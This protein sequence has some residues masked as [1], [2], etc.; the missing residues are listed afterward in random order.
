[1]ATAIALPP[2]AWTVADLVQR[3]GPMPLGRLRFQPPPGTATE[4]DVLAVYQREKHLCELVDGVLVEKTM[5]VRESFLAVEIASELRAFAKTRNLGMVLGA[6]GMARLAPGL[7]RIPDVSFISWEQLPGGMVPNEPML[8]LAPALAVEV[9]SPG[10]TPEEMDRKLHDYFTTGVRLVWYVDPET[11]TVSVYTIAD[12]CTVL[13]EDDSLD[14]GN[15][16]VGFRLPLRELFARLAEES[17][18]PQTHQPV[19]P[20]PR[21][22][23]SKRK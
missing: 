17:A 8:R 21:N 15:L 18:P 19:H 14:G 10:N 20:K 5:G 3:F 9:L 11:R 12:R 1:M 4:Q 16:L 6:D 23:R 13:R 2:A 22:R 7:V